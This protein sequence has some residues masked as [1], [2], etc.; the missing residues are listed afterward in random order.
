MK[1]KWPLAELKVISFATLPPSEARALVGGLEAIAAR[2]TSCIPP[3]CP[4]N[5]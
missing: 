1:K 5:E 4:C 3:D 2:H